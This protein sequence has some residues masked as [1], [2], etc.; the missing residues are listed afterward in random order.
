[1]MLI[2][3]LDCSEQ[4]SIL[5]VKDGN[6]T[7]LTF[8]FPMFPFDPPENIREPKDFCYFQGDL[9]EMIGR[10]WLIQL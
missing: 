1:M 4:R 7:Q 5:L 8:F 3:W 10:K 6:G 9:K 2:I